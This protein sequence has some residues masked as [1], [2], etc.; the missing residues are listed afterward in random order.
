MQEH[1][2]K[3]DFI[4]FFVTTMVFLK[5]LEPLHLSLLL[6]FLSSFYHTTESLPYYLVKSGKGKCF[7]VI[8]PQGTK[9]IVEY[10]APDIV[11]DKNEKAYAPSW[12]TINSLPAKM[13]PADYKINPKEW[14]KPFLSEKNSR[15]PLKPTSVEL[16]KKKGSVEHTVQTSGEVQVCFRASGANSQNPM[17]F[18]LR[19]EKEDEVHAH[20]EGLLNKAANASA[21]DHHLTHMEVEMKHLIVSMKNI[22]SEADFGKDREMAFH[23][24]T[25]SM[26]AA[27][28]WWP[29]VQISVLLLTG[30]TQVNHMVRFFQRRRIF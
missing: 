12:I 24:K 25:L 9:I 29:I 26:H 19:V 14:K 3:A 20:Y 27:S 18:G 30:F 6:L 4:N 17:R 11:I 10:E 28:L 16:Q 13:K 8:V 5:R 1:L 15:N 23:E 21:A 22:L 7:T 2:L